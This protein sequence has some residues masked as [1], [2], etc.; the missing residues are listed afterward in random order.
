MMQKAKA[1]DR[2]R[3]LALCP[4]LAAIAAE[5]AVYE[6]LLRR[7]QK[8]I[9]LVSPGTLDHLWSRHFADSAQVRAAAP[10]VR[11]W[12]DLGSGAGFPG[13]VTGLLVKGQP[14][15]VVHLIESDQRKAAFLRAVSR[16]TG[17]PTEIHA[18]RIDDIL[19]CLSPAPEAISARALAPLAALV[20]MIRIPLEKN[21]IGV[22]LKGADWRNELTH[23]R[24]KDNLFFRT[25]VSR[26][27]PD[28][29]LIIVGGSETG[30]AR[31]RDIT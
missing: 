6:D 8:T 9:N 13:L 12:A 5:L 3:A 23:A 16:E 29:R 10:Q 20:D 30:A 24:A 18:G 19:A 31:P 25:I 28:A 15:A 11:L 4:E 22:F 17:A 27:D 7:W 1:G 14:G 2:D 21:A 26:T